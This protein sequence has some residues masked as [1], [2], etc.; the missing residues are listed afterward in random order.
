MPSI[1]SKVLIDEIVA[2]DGHYMDDPRVSSI[3]KYRTPEGG[4]CFGVNYH[5]ENRYTPSQWVISPELYWEAK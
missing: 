3:Y 2:G 4:T 5:A 1:D